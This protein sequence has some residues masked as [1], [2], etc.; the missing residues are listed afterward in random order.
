MSFKIYNILAQ[1]FGEETTLYFEESLN[2]YIQVA[3]EQIHG[4]CIFMRYNPELK[5]SFFFSLTGVDYPQKNMITMVY[6]LFSMT[7]K[8]LCVLKTSVNRENPE[9]ESIESVWKTAGWFEREA[10]DL[11]GVDFI[12]HSNMKR[13]L[14]PDD[15]EGHPLRKDYKEKTFYHDMKTSKNKLS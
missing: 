13:I 14:L 7:H 2:S 5:F 12:N 6:H 1:R 9:L 15:W 3:P 10:H 11:L 4:V 8:T